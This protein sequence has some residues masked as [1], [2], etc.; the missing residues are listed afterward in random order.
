MLKGIF[1]IVV[2]IFAGGIGLFWIWVNN[3]VR[4]K[5]WFLFKNEKALLEIFRGKKVCFINAHHF[6]AGEKA[7]KQLKKLL[8]LIGAE[9]E[10][11]EKSGLSII[12]LKGFKLPP[13]SSSSEE[14]F[15]FSYEGQLIEKNI[16]N[17][18]ERWPAFDILLCFARL[19]RESDEKASVQAA[20]NIEITA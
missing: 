11:D 3:S 7:E 17:L 6:H 1:F 2:G 18:S 13:F 20:K 15:V 9:Y 8:P 12:E 14:I 4:G 19:I 5:L 16:D 10:E